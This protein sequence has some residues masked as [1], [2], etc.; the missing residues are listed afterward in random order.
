MRLL[1]AIRAAGLGAWYVRRLAGYIGTMGLQKTSGE[2]FVG[3]EL[4]FLGD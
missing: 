3:L 4:I 2:L 1:R